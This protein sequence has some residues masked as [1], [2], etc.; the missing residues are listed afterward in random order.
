MGDGNLVHSSPGVFSWPCVPLYKAENP[1]VPDQRPLRLQHARIRRTVPLDDAG[2][3]RGDQDVPLHIGDVWQ[4]RMQTFQQIQ[5]VFQIRQRLARKRDTRVRMP[6][7]VSVSLILTYAQAVGGLI[8]GHADTSPH[9]MVHRPGSPGP[10]LQHCSPGE[11]ALPIPAGDDSECIGGFRRDPGQELM[12]LD[13]R[14]DNIVHP[15][16]NLRSVDGDS[17]GIV[18]RIP[19]DLHQHDA[20]R[21]TSAQGGGRRRSRRIPAG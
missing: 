2:A 17:M 16:G 12:L 7:P 20:P 11:P 18:E 19:A 1:L 3:H 4:N 15:I 5:D 6:S 21:A 8:D 9:E 10:Q 14:R 13:S